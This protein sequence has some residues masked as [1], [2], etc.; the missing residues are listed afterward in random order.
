MTRSP[1]DD[2]NEE[3]S[4]AALHGSSTGSDVRTTHQSECIV[5]DNRTTL[6]S[7]LKE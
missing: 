6:S 2:V 3:H 1:F 4:W 5:I 7:W